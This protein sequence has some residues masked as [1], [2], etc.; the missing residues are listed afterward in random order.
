MHCGYEPSAA[1][2]INAK[3]GDNWKLLSWM[4]RK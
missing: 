1:L 3:P 2:G 4:L